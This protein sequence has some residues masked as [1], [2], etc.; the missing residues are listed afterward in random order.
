MAKISPMMLAPPLIFLALAGLL[1][2]GLF[3]NDP[4]ALPSTFVG[5][6]APPVV[7]APLGSKATFDN[8][9]LLKDEVKLV[10]FWASWCAPC[11]VEHPH[12][13]ALAKESVPI[14][15]VNYKDKATNALKFLDDLGDPY[16]AVIADE[17]GRPMSLNWGVAGVPETFVID[18]DGKVL[19]RW[20]GPITERV[21]E[22]TIRPAIAKA[23]NGF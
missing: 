11:R 20:A 1:S 10:N 14:Y 12:L 19:L 15:G 2:F 13:N 4:D 9:D 6:M 5:Q 22:N 16:A 21:M 23:Q 3:R 7:S 8:S 18:S 17:K